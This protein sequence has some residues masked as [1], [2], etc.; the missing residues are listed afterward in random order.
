MFMAS[1]M[2]TRPLAGD[3]NSIPGW[4]LLSLLVPVWMARMGR[5]ELPHGFCREKATYKCHSILLSPGMQFQAT[6]FLPK[7]SKDSRQ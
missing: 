2:P 4:L 1:E 6:H 3:L 7:H 5:E